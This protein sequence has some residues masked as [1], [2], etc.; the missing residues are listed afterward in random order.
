MP[1]LP[2]YLTST[3]LAAAALLAQPA[4][5]QLSAGFGT[6]HN[7]VQGQI[8]VLRRSAVP[9]ADPRQLANSVGAVAGGFQGFYPLM[10]GFSAGDYQA[11][12]ELI[13]EAMTAFAMAEAVSGDPALRSALAGAYG[14][15]GDYQARPEFRS[16]GYSPV[17]AYGRAGGLMRGLVLGGGSRNYERDLERYATSLASW[18]M[19]NGYIWSG[20]YGRGRNR[21]EQP[22]EP[23]PNP[24]ERRPI[25]LPQ[26]D[27]TS[28]NE[29]QKT[30]WDDLRPQFMAVSS[31]INEAL[32]NLDVLSARLRQRGMDVNGADLATSYRMQ[33]F[34]EDS[35][36]LIQKKDFSLGKQALDR[37]EYER[38][39]LR[40]VTG[41]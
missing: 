30:E 28:L 7:R 13:R 17:G 16:Y 10:G 18:N 37:A 5:G 14:T 6:Q 32:R 40:S 31:R 3:L 22:P 27:A 25:P 2:T 39:R 34:L 9:G 29:Q 1:K 26:V 15:L 19:V 36:A 21:E 12:R 38:K 24:P 33:G 11:N 23:E 35:A 20:F 4:G 41:Q 8:Q